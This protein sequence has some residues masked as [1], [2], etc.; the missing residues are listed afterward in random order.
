M[1]KG[2]SSSPLPGDIV[3]AKLEPGEMVINRNAV[4]YYGK[5]NLQDMNE[6]VP[7]FNRGGPVDSDQNS[8]KIRRAKEMVASANPDN[9]FKY[10]GF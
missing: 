1:A 9:I 2:I 7:R 5:E 3:D 4:A 8:L 6:S 10:R